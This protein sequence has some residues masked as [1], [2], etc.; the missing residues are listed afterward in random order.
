MTDIQFY[1][2]TEENFEKFKTKYQKD[3][4]SFLFYAISV[5]DY[6]NLALNMSEIKRYIEQQKQ[7]IIYYEKAINNENA[8]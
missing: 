1:V 4:G 2:V 8:K 5:R 6:E 3:V 7:I